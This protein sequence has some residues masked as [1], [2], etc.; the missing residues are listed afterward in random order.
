MLGSGFNKNNINAKIN[1]ELSQWMTLD[2][3]ARM[4]YTTVD[5]L[6][7]GA[8]TNESSA[9]NSIV[10][11]AARFR[12]VDP[13]TSNSDDEENNTSSQKN[14]LERLLATYKK[15]NTFN[16]NYNVGLNWNHSRTGHS[17][18]NLVMAGSMII[19]I[20]FGLVMLFRILNWVIMDNHSL[21]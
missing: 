21:F 4:S 2:F 17:V 3:N 9:A 11:N 12:P 18:L 20:R 7:G 15:R 6:S 8:D 5:G 1:A 14:P 13:L 19:Q 10:A 16:Q